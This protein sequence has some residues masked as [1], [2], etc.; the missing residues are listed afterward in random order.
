M[1]E[2]KRKGKI[3]YSWDVK[4]H[5]R[6]LNG[7]ERQRGKREAVSGVA[8]YETAINPKF[9]QEQRWN[10]EIEHADACYIK[11]KTG[12]HNYLSTMLNLLGVGNFNL[13]KCNCENPD[14]LSDE[15]IL[16]IAGF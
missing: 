11:E 13:Y 9:I 16:K 10:I 8:E 5:R 3:G 14:R 1:K 2:Y 12:I 6:A 4:H 7:S 15:E